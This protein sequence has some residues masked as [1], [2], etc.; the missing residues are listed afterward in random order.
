MKIGY[1]TDLHFRQAVPGTSECSGRESRKM[2]KVLDRCLRGFRNEGVDLIICA[3]DLVDDSNHPDVEKDLRTIHDLVEDI[4]IPTIVI[5]GNHDPVPDVFYCIFP[6]PSKTM[7]IE[8]CEFITFFEDVCQKGESYPIRTDSSLKNMH[9]LLSRNFPN[10]RYTF[11]IQHY[12]IYPEHNKGYPYNYQNASAIRE[13]MEISPRT[14]FSIS[15][16]YHPGFFV[17]PSNSIAYF[18][19]KAICESPFPYYILDTGGDGIK[20]REFKCLGAF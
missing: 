14:L 5:P 10:I 3:G 19:G 17:T 9:L 12:L 13:I 7:Q 6:K 11:L 16:H 15:G 8:D 18:C 2:A 20:T 4:H 1:F